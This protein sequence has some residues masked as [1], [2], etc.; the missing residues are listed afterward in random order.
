MEYEK[1]TDSH[2]EYASFLKTKLVHL[3]G[4]EKSYEL[5]YLH[6]VAGQCFGVTD[7]QSTQNFNLVCQ[8]CI[9]LESVKL[10]LLPGWSKS[11]MKG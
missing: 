10:F 2:E 7:V 1:G 3:T 4:T 11:E 5:L 8:T 6:L 9:A